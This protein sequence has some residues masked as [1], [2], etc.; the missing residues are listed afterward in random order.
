[1]IARILLVP[2]LVAVGCS[3]GLGQFGAARPVSG[4][5]VTQKGETVPAASVTIVSPSGEQVITT[6][7]NGEFQANAPAGRIVLRI[8]GRNLER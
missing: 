2:V 5:V 8:E 1:M 3:A 6:G 4:V 7:Q